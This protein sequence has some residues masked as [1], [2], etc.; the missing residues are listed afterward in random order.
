M[1]RLR[2]LYS[3][4]FAL[5]RRDRRDADLAAEL[6]SNLEFHIED[7]LRAGMSPA[8]AR[9]QALIKLGGLDQTKEAYRDRRTF[10]WLDHALRDISIALRVLAK[11]PRFSILAI[12]GLGLG[13]GVSTAIFAL[14]NASATAGDRAAVQ[15]PASYVGLYGA[16]NGRVGTEISYAD[17]RYYQ[18]RAAS[19]RLMN[20]ESGRFGFVLGASQGPSTL[21]QAEEIEGRF[22]S[23]NFLSALGLQPAFGR[24]FSKKEASSGRGVAVLNFRFWKNHFGSDAGILGKTIVLNAHPL[25]IIGVANAHFAT[26]DLSDVYLPLELESVLTG[27][28]M[29]HDPSERW[30]HLDARLEPSVTPSQA[31]VELNVLSSA[32][33]RS[34]PL[35]DNSAARQSESV[36]VSPGGDNPQKHKELLALAITAVTAVSMILLIAC[37]NLANILLARAVTRSREIGIR[38]ALGATRARVISLLMTESLV[39]ALSGAA[40]GFLFSN[41]LATALFAMIAASPGFAVQIDLREFIYAFALSVAA[42]VSFGLGPA[43]AAS[44]SNL[45][46]ALHSKGLAGTPR[47]DSQRIWAPRNVLVIV[48]LAVS[49]M[50]LMAAGAILRTIQ[51][52]DLYG[53]S[54]DTSRLTALRLDLNLQGYDEARTLQFQESLRE[55]IATIPGVT[56]VAL[57]SNMPLA[58]GLGSLQ[59]VTADSAPASADVSARSDYNVISPDFFPTVG[60]AIQRGRN[61]TNADR[62]GSPPVAIVSESLASRYWNKQDAIGKQI[63]FKRSTGPYFEVIGV[64]SDF[65]DPNGPLNSVRP[66]V[67]VPYGQES[68]LLAGIH[69]DTP[70]YQMQF[71]ARTS[72]N[73]RGL[74]I[75]MRQVVLSQDSSLI[76][77]TQ[78]IQ[79]ILDTMSGPIRQIS[80]LLSALGSLALIMASVGIYAIVSYSV[81]QRIKEIGIRVTLGASRRD[82]LA[83][84]MHRTMK[85]IAWSIG[86]GMAGALALNRVSSS[87]LEGVGSLDLTTCV[88]VSCVLAFVTAL[89]TYMPARK[90]LRVDPLVALRHE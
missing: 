70:A 46:Q 42:A 21:I 38:L 22:E 41:W 82:V 56:S 31:Q 1:N 15:G 40:V 74:E 5:F 12:L 28:D 43:L 49:L 11:D 34:A 55:R 77:H 39:L 60:V 24:V 67:Y 50:L 78:T 7:N 19:F 68:L 16:V 36:V 66:T 71:L 84:V 20:A 37:A 26:L 73:P 54:F 62:E 18:D 87:F 85:L 57:A 13:L 86:V 63:R 45:S 8:E 14:I 17:Y 51:Q 58:N 30:L 90:A 53:P 47:S 65:E 88:A 9:R 64:V 3:R 69:T 75:A 35:P 27:S 72:G 25:T 61:F 23:E 29:V 44:K 52:S 33:L 32:R 48:P 6:E 81:S 2:S 79:E 76:V 4:L 83:M 89:A 80:M 59:F 10:A